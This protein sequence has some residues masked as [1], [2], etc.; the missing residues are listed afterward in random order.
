MPWKES[1][2]VEARKRFIEDWLSGEFDSVGAL[3]VAHGVSRK[4][5]Y[6]WVARFKE[7]VQRCWRTSRGAGNHT[8]RRPLR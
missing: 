6:K 8:R 3:C 2:Q 4:T 5:G 7:G 1:T